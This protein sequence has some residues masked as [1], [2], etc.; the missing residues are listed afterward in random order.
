MKKWLYIVGIVAVLI[1]IWFA[2][3]SLRCLAGDCTPASSQPRPVWCCNQ[4]EL[5]FSLPATVYCAQQYGVH[6]VTVSCQ[7]SGSS[8]IR[9]NTVSKIYCANSNNCN[10]TGAD[11]PNRLGSIVSG[12]RWYYKGSC[13]LQGNQCVLQTNTNG[14]IQNCCVKGNPDPTQ[15]SATSTP[16]QQA[17]IPEFAP[18][19]F[20]DGS[21]TVDPPYPLVISQAQL[22]TDFT[23]FTFQTGVILG[24]I[25]IKCGTGQRAA[26]TDISAQILLSD[27]ARQG[28]QAL[29]QRYYG[30]TVRGSYPVLPPFST[31]GIGTSQ[32]MITALTYTPVDPG[33]HIVQVTVTQSDG[34]AA[35]YDYPVNVYLQDN[36]LR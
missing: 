28:I 7:K 32:A 22:D 31:S 34:Q 17:C 21:S 8:C 23:G 18:P 35:S 3:P 19:D 12:G 5:W 10:V 25:D 36:T 16:T 2:A 1:V 6:N 15:P 13:V 9:N 11:L 29:A 14:D 4:G 26:I 33:V 24:G 27:S 20:G 30:A